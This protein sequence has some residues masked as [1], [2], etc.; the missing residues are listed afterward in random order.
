M[1]S[2]F[3]TLLGR[4]RTPAEAAPAAT[5]S[6]VPP[7]QLEAGSPAERTPTQGLVIIEY[8]GL[9]EIAGAATLQVRVAGDE[10]PAL[11][12]QI[13]FSPG[14][15]PDWFA[16]HGHLLPN[17]PTRIALRLV[18]GGRTLAETALTVLLRNEGPTAEA[19]AASLRARG[20]PLIVDGVCDSAAYDYAD[21]GLTA[22]FDSGPEAV[23]AH[24]TDLSARGATSAAEIVALRQFADEGYAVLPTRIAPELLGRL[25]AALDDAVAN[26]VEGYAWGDSQRL[27]NLHD[28]YPAIREL[29]LHPQILRMLSLIFGEPP[30]PCQSLTYIF[31]SEQQYHQDFIHLT[32]FPAG[33]MCGVWTALE[34]VQP[35]SGELI[36]YPGSHR[37]DRVFLADAGI[38]KVGEDWSAFGETVAKR[39]GEMIKA[40]GIERQ[41]YRP[42]AGEV[43]IWHDNLMHAGMV[44][45]DRDK[46]RRSIVG[47]YFAGGCIAYHDSS[48]RPGMLHEAG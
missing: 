6:A 10:R 2:L 35:E 30:K 19:V 16:L 45:R 38:A 33:R 27:H 4:A 20:A 29:W 47:H 39:W 14:A 41:T 8:R 13:R 40:S 5:A 42:K 12:K 18:E 22:W 34:D 11:E 44:R 32:P 46:S 7:V 3:A 36:V 23:E 28:H 17:G 48:G 26:K 21:P 24:L 9:A 43:L 37:F 1:R 31:G 25:N 15:A